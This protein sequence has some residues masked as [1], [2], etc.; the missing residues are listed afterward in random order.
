MTASFVIEPLSGSHDRQ[1]F[2]CGVPALDRYLLE[3]AGQDVKRRIAF[4]YVARDSDS[5][6]VAGFYTLSAGDVALHELPDETA[7]RLPRYPVVPVARI[8]RLAIDQD[9]RRRGLG[10]ALL[11]DAAQRAL[12]TEIG[13]FA[14]LVDAKD[15]QA[16]AFYRHHGFIAFASK[17]LQLFLPLSVVRKLG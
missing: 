14:L 17:P 1:S 4:C 6:R 5:G 11:W 15:E 9:Y 16:S 10:A 2:S 7:R 3:Q 8:G 12:R 13:V